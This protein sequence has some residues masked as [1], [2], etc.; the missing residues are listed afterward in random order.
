MATWNIWS[1]SAKSG[2]RQ[3]LVN[4][5]SEVFDDTKGMPRLRAAPSRLAGRLWCAECRSERHRS[6]RC[7]HPTSAACCVRCACRSSSAP[8]SR[9]RAGTR[10]TGDASTS[11]RT[12]GDSNLDAPGVRR[13]RGTAPRRTSRLPRPSDGSFGCAEALHPELANTPVRRAGCAH[14]DRLE[15]RI[16]KLIARSPVSP[17]IAA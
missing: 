15:L 17:P 2:R 14:R 5:L 16:R 8:L 10:P 9:W 7:R 3:A 11:C 4:E 13:S 6:E 1:R 12:L